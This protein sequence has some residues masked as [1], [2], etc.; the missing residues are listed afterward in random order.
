MSI[1]DL[2]Q[3]TEDEEAGCIKGVAI[4]IV[5]NNKDE[6]G[7]GRVKVRFPWRENA[8]ESYWARIATLMAGNE[9]G[10]F[11][12]PQVNDEVLVAFESEDVRLPLAGRV[13]WNREATAAEPPS[14]AR[15]ETR[16][17]TCPS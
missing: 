17:I 8:Q 14:A 2:L 16:Q 11:F 15:Y 13:L 12:L 1:Y 9:R 10:R 7:L 5:T 6:K 4:G 3:N